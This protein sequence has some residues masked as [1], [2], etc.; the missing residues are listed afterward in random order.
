MRL[1]GRLACRAT[2]IVG[3]GVA[4]SDSVKIAK[5]YSEVGAEHAQ[6]NYL[7]RG[8]YNSR[9]T[10]KVSYS[11]KAIGEKVFEVKTK[12]PI[13]SFFGRI[14]GWFAGLTYGLGNYLPAIAFSTL[15]LVSKKWPAKLGA[16]GV[17]A[18]IIFKI[19]RD[20]FGVGKSNP[21]KG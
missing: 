9:T 4:L 5:K 16:A 14:K 1:V 17:A 20:G 12:N 19:A 8:Y 18:G 15:A 7:E 13:P 21:M 2:G 3:M 10:D 6:E 11:S